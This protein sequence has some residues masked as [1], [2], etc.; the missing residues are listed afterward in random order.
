ME[1]PIIVS[2]NGDVEIFESVDAA[3]NY[4]EVADVLDEQ[5]IAYDSKG[6]ILSLLVR[7][8]KVF[9]QSDESQRRDADELRRILIRYLTGV[10]MPAEWLNQATLE[11]LVEKRM[12]FD[13][14]F[15]YP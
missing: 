12:V 15:Y 10:R 14:L 9:V 4:L 13:Q 6:R 5:Y 3:Q 8:G 7:D 2:N 1:T 11:Q